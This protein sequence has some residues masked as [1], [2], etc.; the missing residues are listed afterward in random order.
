MN[1]K[2]VDTFHR[3][4]AGY[5]VFGLAELALAYLFFSLAVNSGSL[6]QWGLAIILFIGFLQNFGRLIGTLKHGKRKT[7]RA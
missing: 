5:L 7:S 4:R 2:K 6:W 3:T 1:F